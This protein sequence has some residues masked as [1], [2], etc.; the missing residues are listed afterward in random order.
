MVVVGCLG[1]LVHSSPDLIEL[2][3]DRF[4]LS[5]AKAL[6]ARSA[7]AQSM[8]KALAHDAN[9]A[10][11]EDDFERAL[12][13]YGQVEPDSWTCLRCLSWARSSSSRR[14]HRR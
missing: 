12:E 13:L 10:F 8:A 14:V 1:S 5:L 11:V 4:R 3:R 9:E 2:A 6:T 7:P